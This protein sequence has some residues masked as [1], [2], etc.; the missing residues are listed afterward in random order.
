EDPRDAL[1]D[2]ERVHI[3]LSDDHAVDALLERI[4][5]AIPRS[6]IVVDHTTVAPQPTATRCERLEAQGVEFLHAPVFMGPQSCRE[7]SGMMMAAGPRGRF[8]RMEAAL[9][10]M[11]GNL[12]Y[13]G[14]RNDKAA[15]LKLLGNNMI[16]FMSA[17]LAD[18]YN[19]MRA[20]NLDPMEAFELFEHFKVG[21][22]VQFRGK[23]MAEGKFTPVSFELTMARKDARLMQET[24]ENGGLRL[25]ALPAIGARM[26]EL[27]A[28]GRGSED[29]TIIGADPRVKAAR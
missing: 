28:Q 17:G 29:F 8:E 12:W 9:A 13:V 27:I 22:S 24:A 2:A 25:A 23:A 4:A 16:F 21:N 18:G 14:E 7:G 26:D 6:A 5:P 20:V 1:E 3:V 10:A 11:T 19:M 15:A